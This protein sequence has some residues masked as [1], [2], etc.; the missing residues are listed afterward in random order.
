MS[1]LGSAVAF[2][3]RVLVVDADYEVL[4]SLSRSL[5]RRGHHVVLAADGRAG[6]SRA[7]EVAAEVVLVDRDIPVLDVRTFLEVLRDNPRTSGTEIFLMGTGEPSRLV[8]IDA[9]AQPIV[10]PFNAEEVAARVDDVLRARFGPPPEPELSGDLGQVALFDLLQVFAANRRTGRLELEAR[11]V[12]GRVW[13]KDGRIVDASFG[14]VTGEKALYRILGAREGA[15]VF[16][17]GALPD[18]ER[19]DSPTDRLLIEGARQSDEIARLRETLPRFGAMVSVAVAPDDVSP[20]SREIVRRLDEPRSIDELLDL[21]HHPDLEILAAVRELAERGALL[22]FDPR[23]E[24]VRLA[25]PDEAIA[26]RAGAHRL[27]RPGLEGPVRL[28]ILAATTREVS[29]L[30]RALSRIE[31]FVAAP[32]PPTTA[33]QSALGTLGVL[34]LDGTDVELLVVP[35][36]PELRPLWGPMLDASTVALVLE[37]ERDPDVDVLLERLEVRVIRARDGWDRPAGAR[38]LLRSIFTSESQSSRPEGSR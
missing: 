12:H 7:V 25:G 11:T 14:G 35:L 13:V 36:D 30:A 6:L 19:I 5:R 18:K 28:P 32:R 16:H 10:K 1:A 34:R 20:V 26:L 15:F 4:G 24:R 22:V 2:Q 27:R 9:R 37:E 17:P 31:G 21:V 8:A 3:G 33:G 38:D 23:S 29:R